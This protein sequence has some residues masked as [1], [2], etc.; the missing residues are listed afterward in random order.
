MTGAIS[1]LQK[2]NNG[3]QREKIQQRGGFEQF[4]LLHHPSC[5]CSRKSST[6]FGACFRIPHFQTGKTIN[7]PVL[8]S[9]WM[10]NVLLDIKLGWRYWW[11]RVPTSK[12]LQCRMK[13][14]HVN[15]STGSKKKKINIL[16]SWTTELLITFKGAIY[17]SGVRRADCLPS[18]FRSPS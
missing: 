12:F 1:T 3:R 17:F 14:K 13:H 18:L 7:E 9:D 8:S 11:K 5:Y 6:S 4:L 16:F 10:H 15:Y 2:P